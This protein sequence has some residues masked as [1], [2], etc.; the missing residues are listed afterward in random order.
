MSAQPAVAATPASL[1]TRLT[2]ALALPILIAGVIAG[3]GDQAGSGSS[4]PAPAAQVHVTA[5]AR[6]SRLVPDPA[7]AAETTAYAVGIT[8]Q[9]IVNTTEPHKDKIAA[10]YAF[11]AAHPDA[12]AQMPCYCGCAIYM[13]QHTSLQSCY[14]RQ[15]QPDGKV[16]YT[17]HSLTCDICAGEVDMMMSMM[18]NTPLKSIRD[19]IAKKYGYTGVWTDTPPIQ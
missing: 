13:H 15:I 7:D 10:R 17:D 11:A 5:T 19:S 8:P 3:C 4:A 6:P 14:L 18:D 12:L 2:V 1:R 9:F 16:V